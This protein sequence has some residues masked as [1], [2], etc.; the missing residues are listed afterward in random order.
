MPSQVRVQGFLRAEVAGDRRQLPDDEAFGPRLARLRIIVVDPVVADV[1]VG[2]A[3][4]LAF[5][6]GIGEHL[7][8]A[9]HG[10]IEDDLAEGVAVGADGPSAKRTAVLQHQPRRPLRA[11]HGTPRLRAGSSRPLGRSPSGPPAAS[12]ALWRR[13]VRVQQSSRPSGPP[14]SHPP[15]RLWPVYRL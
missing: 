9:R 11:T 3:Y 15:L 2:H 14:R 1:G 12:A 7:L 10:R 13:T 8:V 6:R 5:V 4:E